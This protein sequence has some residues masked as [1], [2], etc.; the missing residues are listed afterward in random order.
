MVA[1]VQGSTPVARVDDEGN[2]FFVIGDITPDFRMGINT[3]LKYKNFSL[4]T[5]FD[6]KQGGDIY[7]RT[8]QWLYRDTRHAVSWCF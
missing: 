8:N 1:K 4:Y 7:N 6:W 5:L 3:S 2:A